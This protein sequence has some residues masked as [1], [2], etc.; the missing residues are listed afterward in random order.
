MASMLFPGGAVA[1]FGHALLVLLVGTGPGQGDIPERKVC[2]GGLGFKD[3]AAGSVH[4]DAIE[5]GID[6]G[7]QSDDFNVGLLA[8]QVEG[9]RAVF[10]A[11]PGEKDSFHGPLAF[12]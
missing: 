9:P 5:F 4:G 2:G 8:E 1:D 12:R 11:A 7:E 6:G 3:R 10:A